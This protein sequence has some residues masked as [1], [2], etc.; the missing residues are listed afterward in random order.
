MS[1]RKKEQSHDF[2]ERTAASSPYPSRQFPDPLQISSAV[3]ERFARL[4]VFH[5][6]SCSQ[7]ETASDAFY[8]Q[9]VVARDELNHHDGVNGNPNGID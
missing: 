5:H 7:A 4:A 6:V 1:N 3:N 9:S 2:T 8:R